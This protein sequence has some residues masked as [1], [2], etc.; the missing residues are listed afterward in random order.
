MASNEVEEQQEEE[1]IIE[2]RL[3][4]FINKDEEVT[5]LIR[6]NS[7]MS[8]LDIKRIIVEQFKMIKII[9]RDNLINDE[10]IEEQTVL[11]HKIRLFIYYK[12][13]WKVP[14]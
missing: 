12:K 8:L 10:Q 2:S 11:L 14:N 4:V 7:S 3:H 13:D 9:R 1:N 6:F 5:T